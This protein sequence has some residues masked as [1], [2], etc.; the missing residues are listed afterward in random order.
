L[1]RL[2]II[3]TITNRH[4]SLNFPE[5]RPVSGGG[6]A[7]RN[8]KKASAPV[9]CQS[10]IFDLD[11]P[12]SPLSTHLVPGDNPSIQQRFHVDQSSS[13]DDVLMQ[14]PGLVA[15]T[16]AEMV[17]LPQRVLPLPA[18]PAS[19]GNNRNRFMANCQ[20]LQVSCDLSSV[21]LHNNSM[22][23]SFTAIVLI[24]YPPCEKPERRH[25]QLIDSRGSTGLTVWGPHVALFS[26][27][28]VGQVIK[29]SKLS[30][31]MY[32]G[33]KGLSMCRDTTISIQSA[34]SIASEEAKWWSNVLQKAPVRI[35]DIHDLN[36]ECVVNVAGIIGSLST[37][38][39]RV[40]NVDKE[41][42]C[43]RL[44]D[45]SGFVD[46]RSWSHSEAEFSSFL[47]RPLLI[48]RVRVTSFGGLKILELLEGSGTVLVPEF[49]GAAD[50][51]LYWQ[52]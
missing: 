14:S 37:E 21:G 1:N 48:R 32:N 44:T 29:F 22:R 25:I 17:A 49:T 38:I 11:P 46:M 27:S 36:E 33:K 18:S 51:A 23:F 12:E 6:A 41:L 2:F 34:L 8:S 13:G 20:P 30:M 16:N 28:S 42:L 35:I 39:K 45:R 43:I 26:S 9:V 31:I 15:Q 3:I 50:L 7:A 24:V 4:M 5:K 10:S 40:R 47:E 52:E 19:P